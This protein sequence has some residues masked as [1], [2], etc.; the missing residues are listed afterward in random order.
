VDGSHDDVD[1]EAK[2]G[3]LRAVASAFDRHDLDAIMK[4]FAED[5]IFEGPRGPERWGSRFVGADAIRAAFAAR[6]SGIPDVRY[7]GDTH[8]VAGDRGVS[9]WN[10]TGTTTD[11]DRLDIHGCD[12]WTFRGT[13]IVKKDSYWKIRTSG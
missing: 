11:G 10:L 2:L 5:A 13:T 7:R 6:F 8:F 3:V 4:H 1:Q 12:I 9:E